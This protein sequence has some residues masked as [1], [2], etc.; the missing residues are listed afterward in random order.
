[1]AAT[2]ALILVY[3]TSELVPASR[4]LVAGLLSLEITNGSVR[5]LCW[6]GSEFLR[7]I[8]YPIRNGDWGTIPALTVS[9]G[10]EE[11]ST[12]FQYIRQFIVG[13]SVLTGQFA[14]RGNSSGLVE[15][16][17][18]LHIQ[19]DALLNRAG[20]VILH[21]VD[22]VA[23]SKMLV[24]HRNGTTEATEYPLLIAPDRPASDIEALR[25]EANGTV[26]NIAFTGD[27]FEMEDQRNWSD[28]S[29]KTYCR[30]L[31]LPYPYGLAAGKTV[32]QSLVITTS[33][34]GIGRKPSAEQTIVVG[35]ATGRKLPEL[36]LALE[37]GWESDPA[38]RQHFHAPSTLLRVDLRR[39][40]WR[41]TL[42][43]LVT[44]SAGALNLELIVSDRVLELDAQLRALARTGIKA[45]SILALPAA[46]LK[47]YQPDDA[48]PTG[49][50]PEQAAAIAR[51]YFPGSEIGGGVL[52]NFTELNR[53]REAARAGD[54]V[55]HG[56]TAIVHAADD[57][58][59]MQT[60]EALPQVFASAQAL[61]ADKPYRLGLVSIGMRSNPYGADVAANP[62]GVR[63]PMA[64]FD[65][66]QRGLFAAAW[67]VGAMAATAQTKIERMA[68]AAPG[69]P[70][71]LFDVAE[72]RPA[73]HVHEGLARMGTMPRLAVDV[74]PGVAAVAVDGALIVANLGSEPRAVH[75]PLPGRVVLL[76][77]FQPSPDWLRSAVREQTTVLE[78]PALSVAFVETG[79]ADFF[80]TTP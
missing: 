73:Y 15:A 71:G 66:R 23:G 75:L 64:M 20:F 80:G 69:G 34:G 31:A 35:S 41:Q 16:T 11:T 33:R 45:R 55:T 43:R 25:Q 49:A 46:W 79:T 13:E 39:S 19:S 74:P 14:C 38:S 62:E 4:R 29:Y 76:D 1:M 65:P 6:D 78:L 48:W 10:F 61:A 47:S 18:N 58:S 59:V 12:S 67:M 60:L 30:P 3:G 63:R 51:T 22:G 9:E 68:L 57:I 50:S 40:D 27:T 2:D 56:T 44:A 77:Q 72:A 7:A 5:S 17:L 54:F 53:H 21:P 70:F 8:D 36:A 28:A 52:T 24:T 37:A 42:D 26:T 32:T